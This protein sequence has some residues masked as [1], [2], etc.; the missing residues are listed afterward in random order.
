MS[1]SSKSLTIVRP[2]PLRVAHQRNAEERESLLARYERS[3]Q[4]Q[5]S[6]CQENHLPLSTLTYWLRQR[7]RQAP[8]ERR[9]VQLPVSVAAAY[10]SG[11]GEPAVGTVQIRL[12]SQIELRVGAGADPVW[13]GALLQGVLGCSG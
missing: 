12:P 5:K 4:S 1:S 10:L 6:F 2:R 13:V 7:R 11:A 9:L 8:V 3:G